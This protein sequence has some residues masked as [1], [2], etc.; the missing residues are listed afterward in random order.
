VLSPI[1]YRP[2]VAW[3]A[4][5]VWHFAHKDKLNIARIIKLQIYIFIHKQIK[6]YLR[7]IKR[8]INL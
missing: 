8:R 5:P 3:A 6:N 7:E 1:G 4:T 2:I